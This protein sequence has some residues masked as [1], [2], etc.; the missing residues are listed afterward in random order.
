VVAAV[1]QH[2]YTGGCGGRAAITTCVPGDGGGDIAAGRTGGGDGI[3]GRANGGG[4]IW[5]I[6]GEG[7]GLRVGMAG[8]GGHA[9]CWIPGREAVGS[10]GAWRSRVWTPTVD[11]YRL[12]KICTD[13][14]L[15]PPVLGA[16]I[17]T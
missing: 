5:C 4:G 7:Q 6:G 3:A 17:S 11:T 15:V 8:T 10:A 9:C 16:S 12:V 14:F 13:V 1:A 2:L